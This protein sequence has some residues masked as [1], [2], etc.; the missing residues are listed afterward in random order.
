[1][2]LKVFK[3]TK[4]PSGEVSNR[5]V[6]PVQLVD[7]KMLSID[8]TD[9]TD[10]ERLDKIA[11]LDA[12]HKQYIAAMKEAGFASRYRYFFLDQMEDL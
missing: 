6:Y 4:Q 11:V 1:M 12:I 2:A 8:L 5:V 7:D 10:E 3:Y 9:L